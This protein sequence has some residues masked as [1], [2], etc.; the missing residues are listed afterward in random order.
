MDPGPVA[1]Y[2][3]GESRPG[4]FRGVATV[5]RKLFDMIAPNRAYFGKKDAQQLAV[6]RH[7]VRELALS[8]DVVACSTV[9]ESDGLAIS[10]RNKFLSDAERAD[11]VALSRALTFIVEAAEHAKR[12]FGGGASRPFRAARNDAYQIVAARRRSRLRR[13]DAPHR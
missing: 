11:A 8:I 7:M 10:S 1:R 5:V 2:L 3:E 6:V 4:H 12:L 9:R 13:I